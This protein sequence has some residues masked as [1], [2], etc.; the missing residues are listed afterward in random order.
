MLPSRVIVYYQTFYGLKPLIKSPSLTHLHLSSIHF[1]TN[2]DGSLYIHLNDLPPEDPQFDPL[3]TEIAELQQKGVKIVLMVG[4]A[5]GAYQQL[6]SN[7]EAYYAMLKNVIREHQLEGIDLDIEEE[8]ELAQIQMLIRR[9]RK[10]FG[11]DLIISM[12]PVQSSLQTDNPGMGG[13]VYKELYQSPEG[14]EIDYFNGQFYG[15]YSV[16][17]YQQAVENGY[18]AHQVVM[19]MMSEMLNAENRN[20]VQETLTQLKQ[21]YPDFGGVFTWE[22]FNAYPDPLAWVQLMTRW[23]TPSP[24]WNLPFYPLPSWI[25]RRW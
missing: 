23:L 5:G 4:G 22:E 24:S 13:F 11:D 8:V 17:A 25:R 1:G 14:K 9:L 18:P 20:Q 15:D 19:G 21:E 2:K 3:W 6:F 16:S 7:F 12:A 10:D